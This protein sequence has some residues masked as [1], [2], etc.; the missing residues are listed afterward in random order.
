MAKRNDNKKEKPSKQPTLITQDI[1]IRQPQRRNSDVRLWRSALVAADA[2]RPAMLFDLL[3]D[4]MIDGVLSDAVDKRIKAILNA[5]LI[6]QG[7]DGKPVQ[8][9]ADIM[10][11]TDWEDLLTNISRREYWGRGGVEFDFRNGFSVAEIPAKHISLE[12]KTILINA[13]DNIG[14]PYEGDPNI[15]IVGKPRDWGLLLKTAPIAI[16]KRGGFGDYAQWLEIF[17]MPQRIGKYSSYDPQSRKLLEEALE[18]AGSAPWCVIPKESDVETVNN[19]GSG[20]SGSSYNDFRKACNE[21]ILITILGQVLTTIQGDKGARSLGEVHKVVEESKNKADMRFVEKILNSRVIPILERQGY[22]VKGGKFVFPAIAEPLTVEDIVAL[23]DILPI[24]QSYLYDKYGIPEPEDGESIA[25]RETTLSAPEATRPTE[26]KNSD[27]HHTITLLDK[28][29]SF[30]AVAPTMW[31]G[32]KKIMSS[33]GKSMRTITGAVILADDYRIDIN[34]LINEAIKEI[35]QGTGNILVNKS[36]FEITNNALQHGI[37]IS[38]GR[39]EES[40]P[41]FVRQFRENTA[42]FSAFKNHQQTK[43]ISSLLHDEN[44]RLKPFYKFKKEAL[45]ISEDYN[46][47]WLQTEYNTAVRSAR[48]ATNMVKFRETAHLYPNLEYIRTSSAHPRQNHLAYVGTILPI[49]HPW[50]KTHLP[51]SDWNCACSVRQTDEPATAVPDGEYQNPEFQNNTIDTAEFVSLEK[52]PYYNRTD[53]QLREDVKNAGLRF[54]QAKDEVMDVYRSKKG[55]YLEIV[56][57]NGNERIKNLRTYKFMADR[58]EKYTLL[59]ESKIDKVK[60]PDAFNYTTGY[61]SDA[62]HPTSL[63]GQSA[64]QNSIRKASEQKVEE[65]II[66]LDREYS[67]TELYEGFMAALQNGRAM[68]LQEIILV[69][70]NSEPMRFNVSD[71]RKKLFK[72][73]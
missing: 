16:W 10:D 7:K 47:N 32:A 5:E 49:D 13:T 9:I 72:N 33:T 42:V 41:A 69:R 73:K 11:T 25:R 31:S 19:T 2:G 39:I 51:P 12:T 4:L 29:L 60:N 55:G 57:Q 58:G 71:L 38:L 56:Q 20:S 40:N 52:T 37:D 22:P 62:K 8:E 54:L 28:L 50:W 34:E 23:S 59:K 6:F 63:S 64:I 53:E 26:E 3:E 48:M 44:G 43:E 46:I 61:F 65:V 68:T 17:G 18:N 70:K 15:L 66:W 67:S 35:Y 30:F 36:L 21:E 24:P 14:I 27:D 45:K 1:I